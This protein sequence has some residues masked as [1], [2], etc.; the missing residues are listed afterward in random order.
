MPRL[1]KALG[2]H[3]LIHGQLCRP[4]VEFLRP[5]GCTVLEIGPGGGVL[6]GPLQDAGA[7]VWAWELDPAWGF[8]LRRRL[9]GRAAVVIGDALAIPWEGVPIG[10]LVAG[11]LPY[12]VGTAIIQQVVRHHS[13]IPRAAFLIQR[14]VAQRLTAKPGSRDYGG[15]SI[16][17]QARAEPRILG[18]LKP[19]SF[20][21]PPKVESAFVGLTLKPPPLPEEQMLRFTRLVRLAFGQRRKALRNSLAA[22]WGKG[23]ATEV[24]GRA[25]IPSLARAEELDLE[26][27]LRLFAAHED[28]EKEAG[29]EGGEGSEGKVPC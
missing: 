8:E 26:S 19:G 3:H 10:I 13:R 21:P 15:L 24:L 2:Q 25:S 20:R 4:L 1:I 23:A 5:E 14:E 18:R 11:N 9:G 27:F 22:D 28:F 29:K 12:Q 17:V 6:T 7:K 16:L